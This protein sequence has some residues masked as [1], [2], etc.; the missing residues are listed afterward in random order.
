MAELGHMAYY[1]RNLERSVAFY[2]KV[3]GLNVVGRIFKGRAAVLSGGKKHHELLLIQISVADGPLCGRRV[4]LYHVGWKVGHCFNDLQTALDRAQT[5]G[6]QIDGTADHGVMFSLYLRDPDNNEVELYV[7][8]PE[9]DWR[10]DSSWMETP[11]RPLD[12][13]V[14]YTQRTPPGPNVKLGLRQPPPRQPTTTV[15]EDQANTGQATAQQ[16]QAIQ[17]QP[18]PTPVQAPPPVQRPQPVQMQPQPT[19]VQAPPPV[20]R[21]QPTVTAEPPRPASVTTTK[22]PISQD[23]E[24]IDQ[25]IGTAPANIPSAQSFYQELPA[26]MPT[27]APP[28]FETVVPNA[29][30]QSES[31]PAIVPSTGFNYENNTVENQ[32]IASN[33][34]HTAWAENAVPVE[35]YQNFESF[36]A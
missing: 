4:G 13:S 9:C 11:V 1:V 32:N 35:R 3:V 16:P 17:M 8:N 30:F 14:P 28:Q 5:Y 21:P 10:T 7:D 31:A 25:T 18:Q 2:Q 23:K 12:L 6:A 34:N 22:E 27:T 29:F 24:K 26:Q 19:P 20:Q 33:P 15:R 36:A